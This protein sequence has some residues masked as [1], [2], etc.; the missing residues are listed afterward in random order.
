MTISKFILENCK[1]LRIIFFSLL[2]AIN[3]VGLFAQ[4]ADSS[5]V[6][7]NILN[8]ETIIFLKTDS[9]EFYRFVGDVVLQQGT[10]TLYCDSAHQNKTTKNFESFGRVK[11]AQQDGTTAR[12]E[13]LKY[14]AST[15]MAFLK[16][17]VVIVDGTNKMVGNEVN[18]DLSQKIADYGNWGMLKNDTTT[19]T[20]KEGTYNVKS[21][22]AH[23]KK[24]VDVKDIRYT[25]KSE[26]LKY[27]TES[28]V[29]TFLAPSVV[30]GDS[31]RS[32]LRTSNGTYDSQTGTAN[33]SGSS[34]VMNGSNY[35]EGD[36]LFY[37]KL[38]GYGFS[39]GNVISIDTAHHSTLFCGQ[40]EYFRFKRVSWAYDKPV[41]RQVSGK[42]TL[43]MRADT[44]YS[45]PDVAHSVIKSDASK[46]KIAV[47]KAGRVAPPTKKKKARA[48]KAE[49]ANTL[50]ILATAPSDT[51]AKNDTTMAD[52]TAPL[53]FVGFHHVKIFS[54]SLQ[55]KSDSASYSQADSVIRL[56]YNPVAWSHQGQITGDTI[57][58]KLDDSNKLKSLYVPNNALM[59]AQSGPASAKL[60]DQVQGKTLTGYFEDNQLKKMVIFPNSESIY[61]TKDEH[62]SYVGESEAKSERMKI[63]FK[64]KQ[65]ER[66]LFETDVHQTLTPLDK[67][68]LKN[69]H[70]SRFKWLIDQRPKTK[71]ELFR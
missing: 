71:E 16:G 24:T 10:D 31:G 56:I 36:S 32:V 23:F 6:N 9:G 33:F 27:N 62:G 49:K 2:A 20:S 11:I 58:L 53:I 47:Q 64:E 59:V 15:K 8:A 37:C 55:A 54:D 25:I 5:K 7:I 42:D 17:N 18:Y 22:E 19:I 39:K 29:T 68:D 28:K 46:A 41:L 35:L 43:F 4:N 40:M 69:A 60:F 57:L 50:T 70:L 13:Y 44:F 63:F 61:F 30:V 52:T 21:K 26:D 66:I 45:F 1:Q 3:V 34:S 12:S 67:A 38:T 48:V 51:T 14:T 65:I